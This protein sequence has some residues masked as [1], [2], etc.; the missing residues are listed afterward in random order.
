MAVLLQ[1]ILIKNLARFEVI[2]I[3]LKSVISLIFFFFGFLLMA[4]YFFFFP[5]FLDHL[6]ARSE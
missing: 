1:I 3:P 5:L 6:V 4:V 2:T